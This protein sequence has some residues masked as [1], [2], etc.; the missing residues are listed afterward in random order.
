MNRLLFYCSA[1][2]TSIML[3]FP[4]RADSTQG[5]SKSQIEEIVRQYILRH[6]EIVESSLNTMANQRAARQK[7]LMRKAATEFADELRGSAQD[8][9]VGASSEDTTT[10]TMFYD[11]H[12]GFCKQMLP[13]LTRLMQEDKHLR[14]VFKDYPILSP[15][16]DLAAKASIAFYLLNKDRYFD[17]YTELMKS[18]GHFDEKSLGEAA[19]KLGV[20][21]DALSQ[22]MAKPEV[23]AAIAHNK[24][25]ATKLHIIGT[26][27]I[28]VGSEVL[29]GAVT[30]DQIKEVIR[31][32]RTSEAHG[33]TS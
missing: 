24:E 6:P 26:P 31:H 15:D 17:F 4:A 16:S 9:T 22:T 25:L 28:Y 29:A 27:V 7:E 21:A 20:A 33:H 2:T 19:G 13:V 1:I 3:V 18:T 5:L 14:F 30:Y 10:I 32:L 8:P 23:A 11:F 12:C